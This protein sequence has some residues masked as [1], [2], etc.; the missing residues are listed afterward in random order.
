MSSPD[1]PVCQW[2]GQPIPAALAD[3]WDG[4]PQCRD[5]FACDKRT[6]RRE[7]QR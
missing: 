2:C 7:T 5:P 4:Q 6:K 3:S 1:E